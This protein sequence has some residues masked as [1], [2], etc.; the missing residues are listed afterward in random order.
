MVLKSYKR[1]FIFWL[2]RGYLFLLDKI[3]CSD[4]ERNFGNKFSKSMNLNS[5]DAFILDVGVYSLHEF[6]NQE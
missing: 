6:W 4:S 2:K 1:G 3:K 5:S